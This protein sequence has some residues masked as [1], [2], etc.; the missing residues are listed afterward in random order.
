VY[1]Y[2]FVILSIKDFNKRQGKSQS[3][4]QTKSKKGKHDFQH[5]NRAG[6]G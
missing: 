3:E 2:E 1:F 5:G 4:I 6:S